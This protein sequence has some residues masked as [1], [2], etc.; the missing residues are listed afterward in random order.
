[1]IRLLAA[2]GGSLLLTS[3]LRPLSVRQTRLAGSCGQDRLYDQI[4][5]HTAATEGHTEV[6]KQLIDGG[7]E[8]NV[9]D[10]EGL[11]PYTS[12]PPSAEKKVA[13]FCSSTMQESISRAP[14][15]RLRRST[16]RRGN[17]KTK[18][19]QMLALKG[20][21][22]RGGKWTHTMRKARLPFTTLPYTDNCPLSNGWWVKKWTSTPRTRIIGQ[23]EC[24]Q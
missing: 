22:G 3:W 18:V 1:M 5:S 19:V 10:S 16:S 12:R 24:W 23:H 7:V 13:A 11:T 21:G 2:A 15:R 17:G 6:I 20:G 8:A 14:A 9:V 4:R